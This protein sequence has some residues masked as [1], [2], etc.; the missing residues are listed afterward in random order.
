MYIFIPWDIRSHAMLMQVDT[1]AWNPA[2]KFHDH[3]STLIKASIQEIFSSSFV[4]SLSNCTPLSHLVTDTVKTVLYSERRQALSPSCNTLHNNVLTVDY[5]LT[6]TYIPIYPTE[7][8]VFLLHPA[9]L[10]TY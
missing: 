5:S 6:S 4:H 9:R 8:T 7:S 3:Y 1:Q 10:R 2:V